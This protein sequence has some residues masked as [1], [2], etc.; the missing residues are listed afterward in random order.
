MA[1]SSGATLDGDLFPRPPRTLAQWLCC[2]CATCRQGL[3]CEFGSCGFVASI[4]GR[5]VWLPPPS[6]GDRY[7]SR[8]ICAG[9]TIQHALRCLCAS[10]ATGLLPSPLPLHQ[11]RDHMVFQL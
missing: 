11:S 3:A 8:C 10:G 7:G 2:L 1:I 6:L 4:S 5:Q 9:R